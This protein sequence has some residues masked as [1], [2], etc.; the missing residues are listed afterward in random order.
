MF[1]ENALHTVFGAAPDITV[2][3]HNESGGLVI[4]SVGPQFETRDKPFLEEH[5]AAVPDLSGWLQP[6]ITE[7]QG[8]KVVPGQSQQSSQL[9]RIANI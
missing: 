5:F 2:R 4:V 3:Y 8:V 1:D 7:I 9:H 6:L